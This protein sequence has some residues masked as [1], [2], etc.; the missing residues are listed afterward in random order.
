MGTLQNGRKFRIFATMITRI[1]RILRIIQSRL[2]AGS[3]H[4]GENL[5]AR[6]VISMNFN[7]FQGLP[8]VFISYNE[9]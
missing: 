3:L 7:N 1:K 6:T 9:S 5:R 4:K 8:A 2:K